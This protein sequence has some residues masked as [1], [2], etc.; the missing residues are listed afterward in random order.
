MS[1]KNETRMRGDQ[2]IGDKLRGGLHARHAEVGLPRGKKR[3]NLGII[4][5]EN[6]YIDLFVVLSEACQHRQ[7]ILLN[8]V[9]RSDH[10]VAGDRTGIILYQSLR[11][12][13]ILYRRRN[14]LKKE[15]AACGERKLLPTTIK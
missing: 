9:Y 11:P 3:Q 8:V 6:R 12:A 4:A 10:D 7:I 14:I 2:R 13:Q 15:L 1:R 5:G